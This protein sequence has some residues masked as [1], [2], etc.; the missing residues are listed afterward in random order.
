[1][2]HSTQCWPALA[3]GNATAF[4]PAAD[5]QLQLMRALQEQAENSTT[6][7]AK[8]ESVVGLWNRTFGDLVNFAASNCDGAAGPSGSVPMPSRNISANSTMKADVAIGNESLKPVRQP[9]DELLTAVLDGNV[10]STAEAAAPDMSWQPHV[11]E[12]PQRDCSP[13]PG[14]VREL[15]V[16]VGTPTFSSEQQSTRHAELAEALLVATD[17]IAREVEEKLRSKLQAELLEFLSLHKS[18]R[19]PTLQEPGQLEAVGRHLVKRMDDVSQNVVELKQGQHAQSMELISLKARLDVL[20]FDLL[21][22]MRPKTGVDP[23]NARFRAE[24][25]K[26]ASALESRLENRS[27]ATAAS[28]VV[29]TADAAPA[30]SMRALPQVDNLREIDAATT[31]K[32]ISEQSNDLLA[33][34]EQLEGCCAAVT[35]SASGTAPKSDAMQFKARL[36]A[37]EEAQRVVS[38]DSLAAH[39]EVSDLKTRLELIEKAQQAAAVSTHV[40]SG[41]GD[42]GDMADNAD[43]D[44]LRM[45]LAR[46]VR[47]VASL[48]DDLGAIRAE[49]AE[50]SRRVDVLGEATAGATAHSIQCLEN[51]LSKELMA[52]RMQLQR[53]MSVQG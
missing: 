16:D 28:A 44:K 1:M 2:Q 35:G 34:M 27:Q 7:I 43:F 26:A 14:D 22:N 47:H 3:S 20:V 49:H 15:G 4:Q 10:V 17:K 31:C 48:G 30:K 36:E 38:A 18:D 24:V 25:L 6:R 40:A 32:N 19:F 52:K 51:V 33:R 50:F 13:R 12:R 21:P 11:F 42:S 8:V 23:A 5:N 45:V 29:A 39:G 9:S 41:S 37:L 53:A 46:T